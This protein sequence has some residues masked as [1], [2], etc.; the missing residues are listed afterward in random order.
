M[1]DFPR[2][3]RTQILRFGGFV[4]DP[5]GG[6]L[7]RPDG[8][9]TTLRPKAAALL[10]HLVRHPGQICRRDAL[11]DA[12]WAGLT[13][14]DDTLTQGI[15]ELRRL[16]GP[17][18]SHMIR[19]LTRRGYVFEPPAEPPAPD[20]PADPP[21][22]ALVVPATAPPAP[23]LR[24]L[25]PA[26][27]G[28]PRS[29][30]LASIVA[31]SV[32]WLAA[33]VAAPSVPPAP[34]LTAA[35]TPRA[36]AERLH[37]EGRAM[38]RGSGPAQEDW[39][40]QR[41]RYLAAIAADPSFAPPYALASLTHTNM[42][43]SGRSLNPAED[44]RRAEVLAER[45]SVLAPDAATTLNARASVLR[46]HGRLEEAL[47]LYRAAVARDPGQHSARANSGLL[48][49][50]LGRP[51]E[52]MAPLRASLALWRADHAVAFGWRQS[53]GTAKLHAMAEDFGAAEFRTTAERGSAAL[54]D[55]RLLHLAAALALAGQL[56]EAQAV[57]LEVRR[58]LPD[59][60]L[61]G[62]RARPASDDPAYLRQREATLLRGLALA[63]VPE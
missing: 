23:V 6:L 18:G 51:E 50:L 27:R 25:A 40:G 41:D 1:P 52:A 10:A 28:W 29:V 9:E 12:V 7:T 61:A 43:F 57:A 63:G 48:L 47:A 5:E 44:L 38:F 59:V 19:T 54:R 37:A 46:Q 62:L 32:G 35:E 21:A 15:V 2:V 13:V 45:A 34:S 8:S 16:L 14:G 26:A 20:E 33:V 49:I 56:E 60:T 17:E 36:A 3:H 22:A 53:L 39:L 55:G 30:L 24:F 58:R 42:I 11:L 31:G 4:L